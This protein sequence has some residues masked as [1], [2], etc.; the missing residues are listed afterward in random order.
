MPLKIGSAIGGI[1]LVTS[2]IDIFSGKKKEKEAREQLK[3]LKRPMMETPQ[4]LLDKL[5]FYKNMTTGNMPG[6]QNLQNI[7][8][9]NLAAGGG[10][11]SRGAQ[12]S[13]DFMAAMQNLYG[14]NMM[15]QQQ[16]AIKNS[17]FQQDFQNSQR[18]G[19]ASTLSDLARV[20]TEMFQVNQLQP[21]QQNYQQLSANMA[22]GQQQFAQG[23]GGIGSSIGNAMPF[24]GAGSGAKGWE[25]LRAMYGPLG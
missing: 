22:A 13:Q 11:I 15:Q 18:E 1:G 12:G 14:Q 6:Y 21:Y 9:M 24:V 5:S 3:N 7:A 19:Y 17:Q 4:A 2:A 8:D 23:L 25:N 10:A 16:N 20:Q